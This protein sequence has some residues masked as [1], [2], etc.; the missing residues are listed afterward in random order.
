MIWHKQLLLEQWK[1]WKFVCNANFGAFSGATLFPVRASKFANKRIQNFH[2]ATCPP[3]PFGLFCFSTFAL[4]WNRCLKN[5]LKKPGPLGKA[6][7]VRAICT[8]LMNQTHAY[9]S[10][11]LETLPKSMAVSWLIQHAHAFKVTVVSIFKKVRFSAPT[12]LRPQS[13]CWILT[14]KG[15]LFYGGNR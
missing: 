13:Q 4:N 5:G 9:G 15:D 2:N 12:T 14:R 10:S 6:T 3:P 11:K 7:T 1:S 8:M